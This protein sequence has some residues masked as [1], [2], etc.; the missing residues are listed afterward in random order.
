MKHKCAFCGKP[1]NSLDF[2]ITHLHEED[3]EKCWAKWRKTH[4]PLV[5]LY[6]DFKKGTRVITKNLS[7]KQATISSPRKIVVYKI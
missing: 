6:N 7:K 3:F 5:D 1:I 2:P 4:H